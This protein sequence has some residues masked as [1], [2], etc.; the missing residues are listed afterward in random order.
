[1]AELDEVLGLSPKPVSDSFSGILDDIDSTPLVGEAEEDDRLQLNVRSAEAEK[2]PEQE[3]ASQAEP[4]EQDFTQQRQ[5]A[6]E[7]RIARNVTSG[8]AF[9]TAE[10][11]L[12]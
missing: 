9:E 3:Q 11:I 10:Q 7:A 8:Q 6:D 5:D 4:T 1:M 12:H 2:R